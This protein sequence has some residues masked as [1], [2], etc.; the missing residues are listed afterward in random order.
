MLIYN[1][2][3]TGEQRTSHDCKILQKKLLN[4]LLIPQ[5]FNFSCHQK[6]SPKGLR[7]LNVIFRQLTDVIIVIIR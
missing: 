5:T 1:Y 3:I 2:K 7:T 4:K 6:W